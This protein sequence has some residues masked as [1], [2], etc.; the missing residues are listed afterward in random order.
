MINAFGGV[1]FAC[2]LSFA[3]SFWDVYLHYAPAHARMM[4]QLQ[5]CVWH[6]IANFFDYS[7]RVSSTSMLVL[8]SALGSSSEV[9]VLSN[10]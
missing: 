9:L 2:A 1:N 8:K 5:M 7:E 4:Y 6:C 3:S 10:T